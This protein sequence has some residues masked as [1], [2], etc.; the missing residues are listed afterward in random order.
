MSALARYFLAKNWLVKGSD[1]SSSSLT[2]KLIKEGVKVKIGHKKG[3][4]RP[5][6]ALVIYN[7]AIPP[8]NPEIVE[9]RRR[10]LKI[11]S[12]PEA[13]G[14][15]TR[16]YETIAIAGAH[17]KSTTTSLISV[18]LLK[19]GFDPTVVVGTLL[20]EFGDRNFRFGRSRWLVIEADE[21]HASFLNYSPT[22]ALITNIDREHLDYYKN[23][24]NV[25]KSFLRFIA[26]V[27]RNGVLV[28]NRDNK[29]LFGLKNRIKKTAKCNF[30]KIIW[31]SLR[32]SKKL[33]SK[34]KAVLKIPGEHNLSN[35]LGAYTLARHL[36]IEEKEILKALG[37]YRGTWRRME[38]KG[39]LK[40]RNSK[41]R[42][43]V[44][45]DYAHHPTEIKATLQ[46]LREKYP[47]SKLVCVF[48]PHQA[49]RLRLLF[50][51][52]VRAFDEADILV[53]CPAYRVAGRDKIH[54]AYSSEMLAKAIAIRNSKL[55][56][57]NSVVY[58]SSPKRLRQI[59]NSK[60]E[61]LNSAVI[62]MMGAGDIV[63][64]TKLLLS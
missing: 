56:L 22:Y 3:N 26:N 63:N 38:Y 42:I 7:Q 55:G 19:V 8:S 49:E 6:T 39:L 4:L 44:Y 31:Y 61:T 11:L 14:E 18:V 59:L 46:G 24:G 1:V 17:G 57:E 35:A 29:E 47:R 15:L 58:L 32:D 50:R 60:F 10:H 21:F 30:L 48:Q 62:V 37:S 12:Y 45:D 27:K 52:F 9:A 64:Y 51:D 54:K 5:K 13:L 20:K 36:G 16:K 25:K 28:L 53:L 2:Q 33:N 43:P 34:I 23:F 41:F 40:I